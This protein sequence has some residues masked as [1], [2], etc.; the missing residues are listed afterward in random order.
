MSQ[1]FPTGGYSETSGGYKVGDTIAGDRLSKKYTVGTEI[2]TKGIPHYN[3]ALAFDG[4]NLFVGMINNYSEGPILIRL[5]EKDG[6]ITEIMTAADTSVSAVAVDSQYIY[7]GITATNNTY[8]I[9]KLS[10]TDNTEIWSVS[11]TAETRSI[12]LDN[13]D[14][15]VANHNANGNAVKRLSKIDGSEIWSLSS[16]S[17]ANCIYLYGDYAFV[18]TN[19]STL[20][21]QK[22]TGSV[23]WNISSTNA[24][25]YGIYVDKNGDVG[26]ARYSD[27]SGPAF[28]EKLSGK[29]GATL[30]Y[31]SAIKKAYS[32][33]IDSFGNFYAG[34]S[35][36]VYKVSG[37]NGTILWSNSVENTN[38]VI[39]GNDHS[40]YTASS[41][42]VNKLFASDI[43]SIDS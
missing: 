14:L 7:V 43:F 17:N 32:L 33:S 5:A 20:K 1:F 23:V 37:T 2:W 25:V 36:G 29:D 34:T 6:T 26:I 10:R 8:Y 41:Q 19:N 35:S 13:A 40:I 16:I 31:N 27:A 28:L 3:E 15:Y 21:L 24:Y 22:S 4:T 9:K 18:G 38:C 42:Q 30:W 12:Q 39:L 11:A